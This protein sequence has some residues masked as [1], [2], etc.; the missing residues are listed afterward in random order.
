[1]KQLTN[2]FKSLPFNTKSNITVIAFFIIMFALVGMCTSCSTP[3]TL[4][5]SIP[6]GDLLEHNE[7]DYIVI[8]YIYPYVTVMYADSIIDYKY[9][10]EQIEVGTYLISEKR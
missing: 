7:K 6:E 10:L 2:Y 5:I 4:T 3:Q 9:S 1:M 8:D